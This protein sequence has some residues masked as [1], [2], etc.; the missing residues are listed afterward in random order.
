[1]TGTDRETGPLSFDSWAKAVRE[2]DRDLN[3]SRL[4]AHVPSGLK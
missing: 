3:M 1:M 4:T 2:R